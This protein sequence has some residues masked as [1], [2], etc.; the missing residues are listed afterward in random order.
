MVNADGEGFSKMRRGAD[1]VGLGSIMMAYVQC[2]AC[3]KCVIPIHA[4]RYNYTISSSNA[5]VLSAGSG[6]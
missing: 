2:I 4:Q 6:F 3:V 1:A 5:N